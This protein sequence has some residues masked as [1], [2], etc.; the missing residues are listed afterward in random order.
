MPYVAASAFASPE[1][2]TFGIELERRGKSP[3]KKAD[4]T[5]EFALI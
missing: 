4:G 5:D 2:A 3:Q 1:A